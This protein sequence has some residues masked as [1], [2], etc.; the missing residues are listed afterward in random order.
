MQALLNAFNDKYPNVKGEMSLAPPG[1]VF[2]A[3]PLEQQTAVPVVAAQVMER[4]EA[5]EV[6]RLAKLKSMLDR[7]L[8]SQA[9]YDDKKAEILAAL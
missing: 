7:G 1:L 2:C 3:P 8:I 9:E 4:A 5:P 6:E